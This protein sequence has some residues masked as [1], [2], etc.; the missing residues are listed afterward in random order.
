[1][2]KVKNR[3]IS[4]VFLVCI[5]AIILAPANYFK[6]MD[7]VTYNRKR[8]MKNIVYS[9]DS[10]VKDVAMVQR[11][12]T[13][14]NSYYL[15]SVNVVVCEQINEYEMETMTTE[16]SISRKMKNAIDKLKKVEGLNTYL[17]TLYSNI[18][19]SGQF[20][21]M[22]VTDNSEEVADYIFQIDSEKFVLTYDE[23]SNRIIKLG[24]YGGKKKRLTKEEK[25]KLQQS[26]LEYCNLTIVDD[27]YFN[28]EN[29]I[30]EKAHLKLVITNEE[31]GWNLHFELA[32]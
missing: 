14:L 11:I 17:T 21:S 27:W 18:T 30:S 8:P 29:M 19:F 25:R 10:D 15:K 1:M 12:H 24:I 20:A 5:I 3:V 26:F 4:G 9:L 31:Q 2:E 13:I 22:L 16:F 23:K 32:E 28:G 7:K 6:I